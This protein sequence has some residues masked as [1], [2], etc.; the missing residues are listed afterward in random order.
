MA[1]NPI[2][3]QIE[4]GHAAIE[5]GHVVAYPTE[6]FYALGADPH[7]P[8]ALERLLRLKRREGVSKPLLL[9]VAALDDLP[10][11]VSELPSS[12]DKL[13]AHFWPG[14][15]TMV[16]PAQ[17]ELPNTLIGKSGGVAVRLTSNPTAIRLIRA[18]GTALTGT[19]A[20]RTGENPCTH[21]DAVRSAFGDQLKT[22]IDG[23]RTAGGKPST[24]LDLTGD[25]PRILRSGAIK[26]NAITRVLRLV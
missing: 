24:V 9:L 3:D 1:H 12:F 8:E 15:M 22:V 18:C 16:L 21:A 7:Q 11:W 2:H 19:S 10:D 26:A 20:N 23:G 14:P 6:T 25:H 4:N 17:P 5:A 13:V